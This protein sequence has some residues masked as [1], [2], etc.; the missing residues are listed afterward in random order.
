M[1]GSSSLD[2]AVLKNSNK[3]HCKKNYVWRPGP[4]HCSAWLS[5][6][7]AFTGR[8]CE[9]LLVRWIGP[10]SLLRSRETWPSSDAGIQEML[11]SHFSW[12]SGCQDTWLTPSL[13][14]TLSQPPARGPFAEGRS[15]TC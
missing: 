13:G 1:E 8:R 9:R 12:L 5:L 4:S 7:W 10:W 6:H 2:K 11:S 15:L 14:I 3:N